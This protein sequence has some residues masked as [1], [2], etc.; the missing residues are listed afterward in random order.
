MSRSQ[1][2]TDETDAT[3]SKDETSSEIFSQFLNDEVN[4]NSG[5]R[6]PAEEQL[7]IQA[8]NKYGKCWKQV[9]AYIKTQSALQAKL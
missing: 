3:E 7:L 4:V 5:K 8:V 6:T 2:S 9:E 1:V